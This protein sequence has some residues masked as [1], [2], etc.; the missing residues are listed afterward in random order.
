MACSNNQEQAF[1][2]SNFELVRLADGV[3]ACI[4]QFGGKAI[5]NVGIVDNGKETLI[6]DTFLSPDVALETQEIV[7]IKGL[8]PI[9]YVV[10]SH[11][12]NDHIRGNQ[13]FPAETD[14][15]STERT[16]QLIQEWEAAGIPEEQQYAP[17]LFH[18]Y[19]SLYHAFS[20]DTTSRE[21]AAIMMW[22]P[23]YE[24][25]AESHIKVK[26]RIPNLFLDEQMNL[27]GPGRRVQLISKGAG[28]TESDMILYLPDD[29]IVF[30]ADLVFYEMHPYLGHGFPDKWLDYL[31]YLENLEIAK[32][33]PG[34]GAICGKEGITAMKSYINSIDQLAKEMVQNNIPVTQA[35]TISI[36][37]TYKD[38]WFEE[39]FHSNLRFMYRNQVNPD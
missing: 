22:R 10:N 27:D 32:V 6:F 30:A 13:V 18:H 2:S 3:F 26:T 34:H 20:G 38:W 11:A 1:T 7:E 24:V 25:L 31:T 9:K 33:G 15:I 12:H 14:I 16:A 29:G 19:D 35:S 5:C 39:F 21:Y 17:P 8:S 37:E 4:H 28:H 23:Y 36:P